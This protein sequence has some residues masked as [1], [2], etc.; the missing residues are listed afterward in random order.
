MNQLLT[1]YDRLKIKRISFLLIVFVLIAHSYYLEAQDFEVAG[2]V[3]DFIAKLFSCTATPNFFLIS[4]FLFFNNIEHTRECYPKMFRRIRT[5]LIPYILWNIIFVLWY[6]LFDCIPGISPLIN[7]NIFEHFH[8]VPSSLYFLF[9]NPAS[10]PLWFLR[11]LILF[12]ILSPVLLGMIR[13]WGWFLF[14]TLLIVSPIILETTCITYF[15]LPFFVLG[16]TIAVRG[17]WGW[18]NKIPAS[19]ACGALLIKVAISFVWAFFWP[20]DFVGCEWLRLVMKMLGIIYIW[21]GYDMIAGWLDRVTSK[22]SSQILN[23]TFFIYLFHEPILNVFKKLPLVIFGVDEFTLLFFYLINPIIMI[24]FA[25]LIA[26]MLQ[27]IYPS[28]YSL[29]V[30][31]RL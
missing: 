11:D 5:L 24:T 14:W 7:S 13:K 2:V 31:G 12:V 1:S 9:F 28:L 10:F 20:K 26:K 25:I 22:Q 16:G 8:S 6:W 27:R 18:Q 17:G 3:Q 23:Y 4:G 21:K 29:L 15:E 19:M 30:G